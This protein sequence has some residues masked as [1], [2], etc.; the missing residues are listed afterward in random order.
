MYE[1][2]PVWK[3]IR[4]CYRLL[5][6]NRNLSHRFILKYALSYIHIYVFIYASVCTFNCRNNERQKDICLLLPGAHT[7]MQRRRLDAGWKE[8]C[9][10]AVMNLSIRELFYRVAAAVLATVAASGSNG[11]GVG[12]AVRYVRHRKPLSRACSCFCW[13]WW[14]E[15]C[16]IFSSWHI[17]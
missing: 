11:F 7:R 13:W 14:S 6:S 16:T 4:N 10:N 1:F 9:G 15:C 2:A 5:I 17:R 12:D 3:M 8:C